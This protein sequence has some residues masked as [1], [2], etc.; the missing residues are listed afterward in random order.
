MTGNQIS[1]TAQSVCA[2]RI[3]LRCIGTTCYHSSLANYQ[4]DFLLPYMLRD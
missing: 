3:R 2:L 1:G 4:S